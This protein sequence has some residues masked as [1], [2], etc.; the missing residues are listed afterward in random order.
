MR[1]FVDVAPARANEVINSLTRQNYFTELYIVG[2][3]IIKT[4]ARGAM[5]SSMHNCPRPEAEG[6]STSSCPRYRWQ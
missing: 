4:T 6:N 1:D 5:D 2:S 3:V